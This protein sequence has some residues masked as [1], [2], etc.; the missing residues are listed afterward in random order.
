MQ[1][2][3]VIDL[4]PHGLRVDDYCPICHA[5]PRRTIPALPPRQATHRNCLTCDQ[6]WEDHGDHTPVDFDTAETNHVAIPPE[7][8]HTG[9]TAPVPFD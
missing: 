4:D 7:I 6:V 1:R 3:R 8:A 9:P 2:T 5:W